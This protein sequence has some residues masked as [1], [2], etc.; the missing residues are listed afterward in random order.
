MVVQMRSH[1]RMSA[2]PLVP[3][4]LAISPEE[5]KLK[6]SMAKIHACRGN[7]A[8]AFEYLHS[9]LNTFRKRVFSALI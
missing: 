7:D 1:Q 8:E 9:D 4:A 6:F 2:W 5:K 3:D